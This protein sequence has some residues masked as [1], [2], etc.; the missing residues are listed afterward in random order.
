MKCPHCNKDITGLSCPKCSSIVP[1][2]AN[3]CM[4]CGFELRQETDITENVDVVEDND[5]FDFDNRVLCPDGTCTGI[6]VNGKCSECGKT[7]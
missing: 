7:C 5:G 3:Y 1:H 2:D 4:E 6:V